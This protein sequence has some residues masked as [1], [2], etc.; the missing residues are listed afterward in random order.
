METLKRLEAIARHDR[1]KAS[2]T[3]VLFS[4]CSLE[5]KF[6]TVNDY[7]EE[8]SSRYRGSKQQIPTLRQCEQHW[9]DYQNIYNDQVE[10]QRCNDRIRIQNALRHMPNVKHLVL[11]GTVWK[12]PSHPLNAMWCQ[13]D[14]TIIEPNTD[15]DNGPW[16]FSHGFNVMSSALLSNRICLSSL[17]CTNPTYTSDSFRSS[18]FIES[19]QELF[20]SLRRI[21]LY[22]TADF[23]QTPLSDNKVGQCISVAS[24]LEALE[25]VFELEGQR[26]IMFPRILL[27]TWPEL[28]HLKLEIDIDHDLFTA[29]CQRNGKNLRSLHLENLHLFRG[30]WKMLLQVMKACLHLTKVCLSTLSEDPNQDKIWGRRNDRAED[31]WLRLS[32]AEEYLLC[33]SEN[34]FGNNTFELVSL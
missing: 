30:T 13:P 24:K 6:A 25:L 3:T 18:C 20:R 22:L 8:L 5:R 26:Q 32:E 28:Y 33:G 23:D 15:P 14:Y 21:V 17:S 31:G 7:Y 10:L 4:V 11:S 1:F 16:Q 2:I 29:F 34:P 27:A 12:L 9:H 19:T